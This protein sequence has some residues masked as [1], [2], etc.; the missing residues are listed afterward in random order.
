[1]QYKFDIPVPPKKA[2]LELL[3]ISLANN[4]FEFNGQIFKQK[5]GVPMGS[6]M[7]PSLTD[8]RIYEI[9]SEILKQF[10]YSSDISL[11]S[12][13][14]DDGFLLFKGSEQSLKEFYQIA[15]S[16]YPLLK[17]T[18]EISNNQIQ[19]LDV[20]IFKGTRFETEKILDVKLYRKPTDNYQYLENSSAH[21]ASVFKGFIIG[22]FTRFIRSCC[23]RD[24]L[25]KQIDIFKQN[26]H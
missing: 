13:Y 8:I 26:L 5:V 22:D 18:H 12:V 14:R 25:D 4:E 9:V 24:D 19:F 1:M 3:R 2:L 23:N 17:F 6:P 15:N 11:L 21:P 20:T 16:I 7:S 10:P